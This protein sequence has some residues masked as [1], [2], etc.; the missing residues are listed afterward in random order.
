MGGLAQ[1]GGLAQAPHYSG[2]VTPPDGF[3]PP[4]LPLSGVRSGQRAQAPVATAACDDV[5]TGAIGYN[6][7]RAQALFLQTGRR[8]THKNTKRATPQETPSSYTLHCRIDD[9]KDQQH[10][11]LVCEIRALM[12]GGHRKTGSEKGETTN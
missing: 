5:A 1:V 3:Y 11:C 10:D 2:E 8:I 9:Q 7:T 6:D 4:H 12:M